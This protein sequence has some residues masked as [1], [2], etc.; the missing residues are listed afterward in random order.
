MEPDQGVQFACLEQPVRTVG[1]SAPGVE[2]RLER[3]RALVYLLDHLLLEPAVRTQPE[4]PGV[5]LHFDQVAG[6]RPLR[7][8][9]VE[10]REIR[11]AHGHLVADRLGLVAGAVEQFEVRIERHDDLVAQGSLMLQEHARQRQPEGFGPCRRRRDEL[12]G[13]TPGKRPQVSEDDGRL[14][15]PGVEAVFRQHGAEDGFQLIERS[16]ADN[17]AVAVFGRRRRVVDQIVGTVAPAAVIEELDAHVPIEGEHPV[18]GVVDFADQCAAVGTE[19]QTDDRPGLEV[20]H[21]AGHGRGRGRD[22]RR[23]PF[24]EHGRFLRSRDDRRRPVTRL[25]LPPDAAVVVVVVLIAHRE[26]LDQAVQRNGLLR[27]QRTVR[28]DLLGRKEVEQE[29]DVRPVAGRV[30]SKVRRREHRHGEFREDA[31]LRRDGERFAARCAVAREEF[32]DRLAHAGSVRVGHEQTHVVAQV[33]EPVPPLQGD[34]RIGENRGAPRVERVDGERSHV[35]MLDEIAF[36]A[37]RQDLAGDRRAADRRFRQA[38]GRANVAEQAARIVLR[39]RRV[40]RPQCVDVVDGGEDAAVADR[41]QRRDVAGG[42]PA[43]QGLPRRRHVFAR[44]RGGVR[45]PCRAELRPGE[46]PQDPQRMRRREERRLAHVSTMVLEDEPDGVDGQRRSQRHDRLELVAAGRP[47]DLPGKVREQVV[48]RRGVGRDRGAVA[49]E[50]ETLRHEVPGSP[51]AVEV[52]RAGVQKAARR[53][54]RRPFPDFAG[55]RP[56]LARV[57][58]HPPAQRVFRRLEDALLDILQPAR[59][60]DPERAVPAESGFE[61]LLRH[62]PPRRAALRPRNPF[63]RHLRRFALLQDRRELP[64]EPCVLDAVG[65]GHGPLRRFVLPVRFRQD[66]ERLALVR[67]PARPIGRFF[68]RNRIAVRGPGQ[69]A[70]VVPALLEIDPVELEERDRGV[71]PGRLP[72]LDLAGRTDRTGVLRDDLRREVV[73]PP[74]LPRVRIHLQNDAEL[75]AILRRE[76]LLADQIGEPVVRGFVLRHDGQVGIDAHEPDPVRRDFGTELPLVE[77]QLPVPA[78]EHDFAGPGDGILDA[79]FRKVGGQ[80]APEALV[81]QIEVQHPAQHRRGG[82]GQAPD[83]AQVL[84]HAPVRRR[85]IVEQLEVG[86]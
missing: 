17:E 37:R 16:R 61:G 38:E 58:P 7:E 40:Q 28:R 50:V 27:P 83:A 73:Q 1:R 34:Q 23:E 24:Q 36:Q 76:H 85:R 29:A 56:R 78:V 15:L 63:R 55:R 67:P 68:D 5:T 79:R 45:D 33:P 4:L 26:R 60:R 84:A 22:S 59:H 30:A 3:A 51:H 86:D 32:P 71:R 6:D 43:Q 46:L 80:P 14:P 62:G 35:G 2:M 47:F 75:P 20:R 70:H 25:S 31:A 57:D 44:S 54:R 49:Q 21:G 12:E 11:P 77:R 48:V 52:C 41:Q 81:D 65:A 82:V 72:D 13:E 64:F 18:A 9:E 42:Y 39:R 69:H 10:Q 74:H 66:V 19:H 53:G 8:I